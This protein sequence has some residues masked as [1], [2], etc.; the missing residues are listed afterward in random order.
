MK[1][2][3]AVVLCA[4]CALLSLVACGGKKQPEPSFEL[5]DRMEAVYGTV[6]TVPAVTAVCDEQRINTSISVADSAGASVAVSE[7]SFYVKDFGGYIVTFAIEYA[8]QTY[9]ATMPITVSTAS[10]TPTLVMPQTTEYAV[11]TG[12]KFTFPTVTATDP[13]EE[14]NNR[15]PTVTYAVY[16]G[17]QQVT[18]EADGFIV[19]EKGLYDV[20]VTAS[21]TIGNTATQSIAVYGDD[22]YPNLSAT[23]E[24][25]YERADVIRFSTGT[26]AAAH[27]P[28]E[29]NTDP[30][31]THF[32]SGGSLKF[33]A[34]PYARYLT[35]DFAPELDFG[36]NE[37]L[38][39]SVFMFIDLPADSPYLEYLRVKVSDMHTHDDGFEAVNI[40]PLGT[41]AGRGRT[42]VECSFTVSASDCGA[43]ELTLFAGGDNDIGIIDF[44]VYLD[45][46][47]V[48]PT[49]EGVRNVQSSGEFVLEDILTQVKLD[50]QTP[51]DVRVFQDGE[52]L[53]VTDGT[54]SLQAGERAEVRF[55]RDGAPAIKTMY[56][57]AAEQTGN[58]TATLSDWTDAA[59]VSGGE[60]VQ[61]SLPDGETGAAYKLFPAS[62]VTAKPELTLPAYGKTLT[63]IHFSVRFSADFWVP[64]AEESDDGTAQS[65]PMGFRNVSVDPAD[66]LP[67]I[68]AR[69]A[70]SGNPVGDGNKN[71]GGFVL[72][73]RYVGDEW[74]DITIDF[75][76][77]SVP[78]TNG[79]AVWFGNFHAPSHSMVPEPA[80]K[81]SYVLLTAIQYEYD[82]DAPAFTV[83]AL[84]TVEQNAFLA[85]PF[86]TVTDVS[87]V[88]TFIRVT[89]PSGETLQVSDGRYFVARAGRYTV[90]YY[91]FDRMGNY[92]VYSTAFDATA[93]AGIFTT[94]S[95]DDLTVH[96]GYAF[97]PVPAK[98]YDADGVDRSD[99]M[100]W[101]IEK[102][103][104]TVA[105]SSDETVVLT[106]D[107][108]HTITYYFDDARF[109]PLSL[110]F[111]V[112]LV[113]LN[114][115]T[116]AQPQMVAAGQS[117][118]V[119]TASATGRDDETV[120][121]SVP[122]KIVDAS[123]TT[124]ATGDAAQSVTLST[125]G[126]YQL[127]FTA[128]QSPFGSAELRVPL[129]AVTAVE[130]GV[131]TWNGSAESVGFPSYSILAVDS[132]DRGAPSVEVGDYFG[133]QNV[134]KVTPADGVESAPG[135]RFAD[136]KQFT[137]TPGSIVTFKV[138]LS[139]GYF[140]GGGG[141]IFITYNGAAATEK[142]STTA[143]VTGKAF[144]TADRKPY[145]NA[146]NILIRD[147]APGGV[148]MGGLLLNA[149]ATGE[150]GAAA[151]GL[152]WT[153]VTVY[154]DGVTAP[155]LDGLTVWFFTANNSVPRDRTASHIYISS[156]Q[157]AKFE[158]TLSVP[159]YDG[160]YYDNVPVTVLPAFYATYGGDTVS[161]RIT[162]EVLSGT[163]PVACDGTTF[164]PATAGAYTVRYTLDWFG[165]PYTENAM[166]TVTEWRPTIVWEENYTDV[167]RWEGASATL[168]I[169]KAF[170]YDHDGTTVLYDNVA[171][172]VYTVTTIGSDEVRENAPGTNTGVGAGTYTVSQNGV[173]EL[174]YKL[175][176][177]GHDITSTVRFEAV[178]YETVGTL[179]WS[180]KTIAGTL[181]A[182]NGIASPKGDV[183][184]T[185]ATYDGVHGVRLATVKDANEE[186]YASPA[187][188]LTGS[189][190]F[191]ITSDT[192]L[193]FQLKTGENFSAPGSA[194]VFVTYK[195]APA[196]AFSS[197]SVTLP[198]LA[199]VTAD[200]TLT[201]T[202]GGILGRDRTIYTGSS[203][204][205]L[206]L[207]GGG[208]GDAQWVTITVSF[209]G[210]T[211]PTL[212]NLVIS[213]GTANWYVQNTE[214][215][216]YVSD[217][218][219]TTN[220]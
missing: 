93:R 96:A 90:K 218:T 220:G 135:I 98:A 219:F 15:K 18:A 56:L 111:S 137:L 106:S 110:D 4:V 160:T 39:Y 179:E 94:G 108:T 113:T 88:D 204:G 162:V 107:G 132:L 22:R 72:F 152:Q 214:T 76:Q 156:I 115:V 123:G 172:T 27:T 145:A 139:D 169:Y 53:I 181:V 174:E 69:Y 203:T 158:P 66:G 143:A 120:L 167:L 126:S 6:Y 188:R 133:E 153:T 81:D 125:A 79:I 7:N 148:S 48:M 142:N 200:K 215:C 197:G 122:W 55:F 175:T 75:T 112:Q 149:G 194:G 20:R 116:D 128:A 213:F 5:P 26:R 74:I 37:T 154:F 12:K 151:D 16:K 34:Q 195:N 124:V 44:D 60:T 9:T 17:E 97:T 2:R 140:S 196:D 54:V 210:I 62:G 8:G 73:N 189:D 201:A 105:D 61:T 101:K 43:Y 78:D 57:T 80:G 77:S 178:K 31:Y 49:L 41:L 216:I 176:H 206:L 11:K 82:Y 159:T 121:S 202:G 187:L 42:W 127:I 85:L 103:G 130:A 13:Y 35:V 99:G 209:A 46:F 47:G 157:V 21:N 29:L 68:S 118:T 89:D 171:W 64:T 141:G 92:T 23:F 161:D 65:G 168:S 198:G 184:V 10:V 192:V 30:A 199:T 211:N 67:V 117:I 177:Y 59:R 165:T 51:A 185:E 129:H 186:L 163:T 24:P 173:Y 183:T 114:I 182:E 32:G 109:S 164:T 100:K 25:G 36:A 70:E 131:L 45:D 95:W 155:T 193:T 87:E 28:G 217:F 146:G 191:K 207:Q 102:D 86:P 63:Q 50:G 166:L 3:I 1:K 19:A 38:R 119:A 71:F 104:T 138:R 52:K 208:T 14:Y 84:E 190:K 58:G 136:S 170:A 144:I 40:Y 134:L 91:A 205:G 147:R 150:E 212:E 83:P 33:P 180:D